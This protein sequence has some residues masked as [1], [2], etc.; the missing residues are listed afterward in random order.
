[1]QWPD[2]DALNVVLGEARLA[3]DPRFNAMNAVLCEPQG[4]ETFGEARVA[5]ARERPAIRHYE[6]PDANK[7]WHR[8]FSAPHREL[9]WRHRQATPFRRRFRA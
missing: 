5:Q 3:L 6:G 4:A 1:L 7:P 2:Q 9:Y 8:K